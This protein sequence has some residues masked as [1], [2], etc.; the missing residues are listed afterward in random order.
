M[1]LAPDLGSVIAV[2]GSPLLALFVIVRL[3]TAPASVAAPKPGRTLS[4]LREDPGLRARVLAHSGNLCAACGSAGPLTLHAVLPVG[5]APAALDR[6]FQAL[7]P[8]CLRL[9]SASP[10]TQPDTPA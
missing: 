8:A 5:R 10:V 4:E 9:R 2:F 1:V 3:L 6:R 7:C